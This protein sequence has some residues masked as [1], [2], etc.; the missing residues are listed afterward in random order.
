MRI[1]VVYAHPVET[2]YAAALH[3]KSVATLRRKHE[4][5]DC[6][7]YAEDFNPVMSRQERI[8]YH[9]PG[10]NQLNVKPW[11]DRLKAAEGL[12]FCFPVW[13]MGMPAMMKGFMDKVFLPGVSFDLTPEG[14]FIPRLH[15]ISRFGV[16]CTYGGDRFRTYLMG[17]P[18]RR[19]L[20]R[21]MR[22]LCKPGTGCDYIALYDMNHTKPGPREAFLNKV[23]RRLS[24]W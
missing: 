23:E 9:T 3:A 16:V 2:S 1:L 22:M 12:L 19:Y 24:R 21:S 11:V 4:V 14:G 18:P 17:D 6:D 8:D 5:D 20:K 15:N 7:L 10:V 13:N